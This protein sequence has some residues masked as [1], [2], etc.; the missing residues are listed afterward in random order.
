MQHMIRLIITACLLLPL[1]LYGQ[2]HET[3]GYQADTVRDVHSLKDFFTKGHV[4]GH[5]RHYYMSTINYGD[6]KNWYANGVGGLLEYRT[7]SFRGFQFGISGLFIYNVFSSD[8]TEVDGITGDGS[9]YELQLF[10]LNH[11]EN[12]KDLDRLDEL[13]IKY[14]FGKGSFIRYGKQGI[15][16]PL[17][18]TQDTRM[19]PYMLGGLWTEFNEFKHL[20]LNIGWFDR[21]S[22]RSTTEWV[23]LNESIGI[24]SQGFQPSGI[25]ADYNEELETNWVGVL[26]ATW[27]P[28]EDLTFQ[29][30][31]YRIQNVSNSTFFQADYQPE[32]AND[33]HLL[34]G[35][36]FLYQQAVNHGGHINTA[37]QYMAKGEKS[38]L[39]ALRA[40]LKSKKWSFTL[41]Y[42]QA[43]KKGRFV[44]PRE[45]GR[46]QFYTTVSRGRI[47]GMGDVKTVMGTFRCEMGTHFR[48]RVDL[49]RTIAPDRENF[50]LNKHQQIS[51]NHFNFDLRYKFRGVLE[52]LDIRFLY[53]YKDSIEDYSSQPEVLYYT[54][55]FHHFNLIT[56]MR[57]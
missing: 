3:H 17:M 11:P 13:F 2:H 40:G 45:W 53:V 47:E 27:T 33:K 54:S 10:D 55:N 1:S 19:K 39:F 14:S 12:T 22:V 52:G 25:V 15:Y 48:V 8:F 43:G 37:H 20:R 49:G 31:N 6:L 7:A 46:E 26:G 41:N 35:G 51:Y 9:R 42:L 28:K 4:G 30:W 36:Q 44:F 24:Y 23:P 5:A 32:I 18:N 38:N 57:F 21:A 16:S 50:A 29:A 56:N 34:L